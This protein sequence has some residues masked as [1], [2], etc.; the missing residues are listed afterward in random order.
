MTQT[1]NLQYLRYKDNKTQA[2]DLTNFTQITPQEDLT[3]II[4]TTSIQTVPNIADYKLRLRENIKKL[5]KDE[6]TADSIYNELIIDL[7][8]GQIVLLV[9]S[10]PSVVRELKKNFTTG[11]NPNTFTEFIIQKLLKLNNQPVQNNVPIEYGKPSG[12]ANIE[13]PVEPV[14]QKQNE[15]VVQ[16]TTNEDKYIKNAIKAYK[17]VLNE[18]L[19]KYKQ[20]MQKYPKYSDKYQGRKA[21]FD[22]Y[23]DYHEAINYND[24]VNKLFNTLVANK[25]FD[26]NDIKQIEKLMKSLEDDI[27]NSREQYEIDK[28]NLQ[29]EMEQ[30]QI[31]DKAK[32]DKIKE[33]ELA[34][35]LAQKQERD[36][37]AQDKKDAI[38][39]AKELKEA[40]KIQKNKEAQAKQKLKELIPKVLKTKG[41]EIK[42]SVSSS[43]S[44]KS[45]AEQLQQEAPQEQ[46][47][48]KQ[49]KKKNKKEE[50]EGEGFRTK[51]RYKKKLM[52]GR[53]VETKGKEYAQINK[54]YIDI[55]ALKKSGTLKVKYVKN[56]NIL[57]NLPI[58]YGL[59]DSVIDI[60]LDLCN[61]K[62]DKNKY[63]KLTEKDKD[64]IINFCNNTHID[65]GISLDKKDEME[66]QINIYIGEYN[67]GNE[68]VAP[69]LIKLVKQAMMMNKL[70]AKQ[71]LNIINMVE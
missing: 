42:Q 61:D 48:P 11:I 36:K 5:T 9:D 57:P 32:K 65:V 53:G 10:F 1:K 59:A 27:N 58:S 19:L 43:S 37:I 51:G 13:E 2:E 33:D 69:K 39:K 8:N 35:K 64:I 71:G 66:K 25:E 40:K 31:E 56:R 54:Y 62:F 55:D 15:T 47:V 30:K 49:K 26:I 70:S 12:V 20:I 44:S 34:L 29:D 28:N 23:V 22:N 41:K 17:T 45:I 24:E 52:I 4:T 50:I 7:N 21:M 18:K 38:K 3:N 6:E 60:I 68:S 63:E 67:A 14:E 16:E 46:E